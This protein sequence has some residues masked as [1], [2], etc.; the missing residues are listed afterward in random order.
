M[1]V[2]PPASAPLRIAVIGAGVSGLSAAWLLSQRHRVTLYEADARLGGHSHTVDARLGARAVP[3]DTGFIVYN[4]PTYPNLTAMFAHLGVE[5]VKSDMSFGVSLDHGAF[6]YS[7]RSPLSYLRH[8][9]ILAN[10]RMWAVAR[11][12]IR[13]YRTGPAQMRALAD[14]GLSLGEFLDRCGYDPVFQRDHLLPQAAAIWSCSVHEI[15]DYPA[16]AFVEFC[17]SHGLMNF[18]DRPQWRSVKGGSRSYVEKLSRAVGHGV[19]AG[20]AVRSVRRLPSGVAVTDAG[21][22]EDRFDRVLVATHADQALRMLAEPTAEQRH[23]LGAFRYSRNLAVLHTDAAMM[24]V[25]RAWWSSWN[26]LGRTGDHSEATV[27]YW[28]NKLQRLRTSTPMFVTL[29]PP[30]R[31]ALKGELRRDVYEH[32][33]FDAAAIAAQKRLWPL[34][35]AGGIWFAGSYF[36]SGFHE[37]GLQAGLAAAEQLGGVRRPWTV[38]H[39]SGRIHVTPAL[40]EMA[41]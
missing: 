6:E 2:Q 26:Y 15:A 8:P 33:I 28:M 10:P 24:P 13:F 37:D 38:K 16:T 18:L 31:L 9:A 17:D 36:G 35:G 39:E 23:V 19:R 3:V 29:N 7:S 22:R 41:A 1:T 34:Q 20:R 40:E 25:R 30:E 4:E 14:A 32:P 21:G 27:T 5:T 11:E 12:V